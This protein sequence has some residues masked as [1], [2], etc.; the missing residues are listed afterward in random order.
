[1]HLVTL[2][3]KVAHRIPGGTDSLRFAGVKSVGMIQKEP[4]TEQQHCKQSWCARERNTAP[5]YS[6]TFQ[7]TYQHLQ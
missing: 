2:R 4:F 1:M 6:F 7:I 3:A 5:F